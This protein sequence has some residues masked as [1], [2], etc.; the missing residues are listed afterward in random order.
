M[1][2]FIKRRHVKV[3]INSQCRMKCIGIHNAKLQS[4]DDI[5]LKYHN[6]MLYSK[7][8]NFFNVI[9]SDA[10]YWN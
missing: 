6:T 4:A 3:I 10:E 5:S 2:K 9:L 7:R 8:F 1:K